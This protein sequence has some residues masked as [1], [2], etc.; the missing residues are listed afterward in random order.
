MPDQ[1]MRII[2]HAGFHKTGTTSLQF[3]LDRNRA[4]LDRWMTYYGMIEFFNAGAAARRYGQRP[5]PWRM[6]AFRRKLRRFLAQ[7]PDVPVLVLSRESFSGAMPG[8]LDWRGRRV[9]RYAPAAIPLARTLVAEL[10]RRFGPDARIEFLYTTRDRESWLNSV[11]GHLLRSIH[12]TDTRAAF[13]AGFG[14][15]VDLEDEARRIAG[16]VSCPLH[17]ARLEDIGAT[18]AGPAT[19]VLNLVGVPPEVQLRLPKSRRSNAGQTDALRDQFL[20]LNRSGK[21]K[22]ELKAIKDRMMKGPKAG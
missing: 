5:F 22:S 12:L 11:Y 14:D 7:V 17:I 3:Y 4:A 6:W 16:A 21:G 2:V 8:H 13:V 19:A 20:K 10:R 18:R 9:R 15:L 1:A